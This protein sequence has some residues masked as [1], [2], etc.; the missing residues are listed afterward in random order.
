MHPVRI[1]SAMFAMAALVLAQ[2]PDNTLLIIAD[3]VGVDGIACYGLGASPPPTPNIDALA[4][5]GVRFSNA[6]ACPLC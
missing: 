3:D 2:S 5:R 6:Q 1:V 4:Q